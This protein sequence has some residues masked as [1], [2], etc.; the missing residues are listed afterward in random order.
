MARL[1]CD[2]CNGNTKRLSAAPSW[3]DNLTNEIDSDA[4]N[5]WNDVEHGVWELGNALGPATLPFGNLYPEPDLGTTGEAALQSQ[6]AN[7]K[8]QQ[9]IGPFV[10]QQTGNV[11]AQGKNWLM[12]G[13]ILA[14]TFVAYDL[15][16]D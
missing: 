13:L 9:N 14:G 2:T 16:K 1:G 6:V 12:I 11:I 4:E 10:A 3:W 8:A 5:L 7:A 15:L